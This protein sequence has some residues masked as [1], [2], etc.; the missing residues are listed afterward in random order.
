MLAMMALVVLLAS[1]SKE[2]A[3][4]QINGE[5]SLVTFNLSTDQLATK[6]VGDG[7]T[8]QKLYYAVYGE[9]GMIE[10]ISKVT[11]PVDMG[12]N[13]QYPVTMT[14]LNGKA[15]S[16]IFWAQSQ[17]APCTI[18]WE[19]KT[20]TYAP[21]IANQESY[22]AFF[23]YVPEFKVTGDKTESVQLK[24][25]FA[26]LNIATTEDDLTDLK[27]Y[28]NKGE[29]TV[30][31]VTVEKLPN[32]LNLV[33]GIVSGDEQV[34]YD[35]AN[36]SLLDSETFPVDG[37]SKYLAMNYVLVN[38]QT[39]VDVTLDINTAVDAQNTET[40]HFNNIPVKR[41]YK[42]NIY[43]DLY[44]SKFTYNV[45]IVPGFE[46]H[47]KTLSGVINLEED[48]AIEK[49]FVV[50]KGDKAVIN[51]N[52]HTIT[53]AT[54]NG[55]VEEENVFVV[56][57]E[58]TI[59]GEGTVIAGQRAV[60]ARG[61]TG[62]VVNIYG[63]TFKGSNQADDISEVIYASGNGTINIYGGYFEAELPSDANG[64]FAAGVYGVLNVQDNNQAQIK[65]YGGTFNK[66]DPEDPGTELLSWKSA[67]PNGFVVDGYK[68]TNVGDNYIV[69]KEDVNV[70]ATTQDIIEAI[71][72]G[73]DILLGTDIELTQP[74]NVTA[75]VVVNL[76][77]KKIS[78]K[79]GDVFVVTNGTL[80]LE[81]NGTVYGSEDNSSSS[82]A[83]WA[84]DY[85]KVVIKGGTYI[86]G[87]D[88]SGRTSNNWRNDCIYAKDNGY[89][90]VLG[91][92]F[93]YTGV[94]PIGVNYILNCK[95]ADYR[96]GKC[97]IVVKGGTF[98]GFNPGASNGEN[99]VANYVAEGYVSTSSDNGETYVV[100]PR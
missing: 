17:G 37:Y 6:A 60:W 57:G 31:K 64:P 30:A 9:S 28:W 40:K 88:E 97:N 73:K 14:L 81:G 33:D 19:A 7:T 83:V 20:M 68:S 36:I 8:A 63:G 66:F 42:T 82:S 78:N 16:I 89:I 58:L 56:Y 10:Q 71:V 53:N 70:V 46:G 38:D 26:Q 95:D 15:Y 87:D 79:T 29:Y 45:D 67:H 27:N 91:G 90:E 62:A 39:L 22:D 54:E 41:N 99:P 25:P 47:Y 32:V 11:T 49:S 65:V 72:A 35:Y 44:A 92:E 96:A 13:L 100:K 48:M 74:V 84:K 94:N 76:G 43:G 75:D 61:E 18:D 1:C 93:K 12:G 69:S 59:Q 50:A 34:V 51:L 23:A 24:R 77:E 21:T 2:E 80:T 5:E 85:G 4:G 52:G 98:H 3:P 55:S 86:V